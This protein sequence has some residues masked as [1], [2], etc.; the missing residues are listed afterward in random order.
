MERTIESDL[1]IGKT[2]DLV[3]NSN[4]KGRENMIE[5]IETSHPGYLERLF[6][7]AL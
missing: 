3:C 6:R 2:H 5:N 1:S 7:H 4:L